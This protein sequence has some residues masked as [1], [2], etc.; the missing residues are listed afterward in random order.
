MVQTEESQYELS[1]KGYSA[2]F[3]SNHNASTSRRDR[4]LLYA[5]REWFQLVER[6]E[7]S[8]R[9]M[10]TVQSILHGKPDK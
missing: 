2:V 10:M 1:P 9:G 3:G 4:D 7:P 6:G 5:Q 8:V